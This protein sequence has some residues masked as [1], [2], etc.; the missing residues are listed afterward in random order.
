MT[1]GVGSS[2]RRGGAE[3]RSREAQKKREAGS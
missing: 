3:R 2:R 1:N